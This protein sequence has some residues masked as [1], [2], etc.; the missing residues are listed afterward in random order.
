MDGSHSMKLGYITA[1]GPGAA[2]RTLAALVERLESCG[3]R[4]AGTV[5]TNTE[6]SDG[7][8]CDMDVR[9]LDGGPVIRISQSL[10]AGSRGCRLHPA[11]LE[12]AVGEV[13]SRLDAQLDLVIV[14]KFGKHEAEGRGFRPLIAEALERELYVL[15]AVNG[16]NLASF[17]E[18]TGGLAE[19]L[20]P[21]VGA[22]EAWLLQR[23]QEAAA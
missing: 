15:V 6:S 9:V 8:R 14:N 20:P 22:I 2:D 4:L 1:P 5:Q 3:F 21:D 7:G 17:L 23:S 12:H 19:E 13:A 16:L 11:A 10:G 18:F